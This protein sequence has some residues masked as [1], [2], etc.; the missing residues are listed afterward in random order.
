[1]DGR[2]SGREEAT[3]FQVPS[4]VGDGSLLLGPDIIS[5]RPLELAR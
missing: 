4:E 1:M 5:V 2:C 3:A